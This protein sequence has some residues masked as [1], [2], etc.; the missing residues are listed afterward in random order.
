M[1]FGRWQLI[2]DYQGQ[3]PS[4]CRLSKSLT[5]WE[6]PLCLH[7][8][9]FQLISTSTRRLAEKRRG[10]KN[11][12]TSAALNGLWKEWIMNEIETSGK[13]KLLG[14]LCFLLSLPSFVD[15]DNQ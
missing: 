4:L 7:L 2:F 3:G 13:N 9:L 1:I 6:G 15:T 14:F 11:E 8:S 10:R 5:S 12:I